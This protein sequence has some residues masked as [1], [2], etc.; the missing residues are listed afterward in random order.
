[1]TVQTGAVTTFAATAELILYLKSPQN[2]L[3]MIPALALAKLY[4]NTLVATLNSRSDT[5]HSSNRT[6][7]LPTIEEGMNRGQKRTTQGRIQVTTVRETVQ[8][9]V[10]MVNLPN[11]PHKRP[12]LDAD[13]E[14][15]NISASDDNKGFSY[16]HSSLAAERGRVVDIEKGEL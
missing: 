9:D 12:T 16:S 2:N 5:F 14:F 8:D 6:R 13:D 11:K 3:H 7:S 15:D 1:M 4:T 10:A